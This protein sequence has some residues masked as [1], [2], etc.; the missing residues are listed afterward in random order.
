MSRLDV[1]EKIIATKVA[2]GLKWA[3]VAREVGLSKELVTAARADV[4]D[5]GLAVDLRADRLEHRSQRG[6]GLDRTAGH[7]GRALARAL[8]AAGDAGAD[9]AQAAGGQLGR[10]AL[11]V[12]EQA[13]AAVDQDVAGRQQR[14]DLRDHVVHRRAGVDHHQ[15][16]ARRGQTVHEV[17]QR[18]EAVQPPGGVIGHAARHRLWRA[19]MQADVEAVVGE[20]QGQAAAHH[21][22]ADQADGM[23]G[24]HA[25]V[26]F[27]SGKP[28]IFHAARCR[29]AVRGSRGAG[30]A[31]QGYRRGGR[32]T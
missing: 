19:V 10:A 18:L 7:D 17:G 28:S 16:L 32:G 23:L 5:A 12:G 29:P 2:K 20:V 21:P 26:R 4:R 25:G 24:G 11:G 1:T 6:P 15:H 9:E 14:R 30:R 13:V 31:R 8:L 3:D 27:F 22:Q